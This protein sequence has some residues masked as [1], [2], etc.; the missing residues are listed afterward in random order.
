MQLLRLIAALTVGMVVLAGCGDTGDTDDVDATDAGTDGDDDVGG[1]GGE[2]PAEPTSI[3]VASLPNAFLAAL[4]VARDDGIFA[5]EGLEVEIVELESGLDGVAAV[6]SGNAQFADIGFED[7]VALA[8][9]GEESLVMMHN[10]LNRVTLTLVMDSDVAAERG[11]TRDSSIEERYQGLEGLRLGITSPGAATDSYMRY[12]LR[13][14]GLD[15]DRDAEIIAI[16]GGASLLAAL[17]SEQIDAYH[18]SPP[19]P[20]VAENEGFGTILINGPE[21]DVPEFSDFLYTGF[22]GNRDWA[23]E[24]PEVA[25]AFSRA[26]NRAM[27][28]VESDSAAVAEQILDDLGTDELDVTEQT[29][30]ALLPALSADGCFTAEGV[31][32]SLAVMFE[33]GITEAEGDAAEDVLWT[34]AYNGC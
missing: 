22:A 4:Y 14:A 1:D 23:E 15:P 16:G 19:T 3:T 2:E 30:T 9:E 20:F 29:L 28:K 18:L 25:Q 7:L 10:V 8:N 13:Q 11:L 33:A 5:E 34:N 27:E 17:E 6:V 12:Y 26:L 24:N 31:E 32:E 21:G